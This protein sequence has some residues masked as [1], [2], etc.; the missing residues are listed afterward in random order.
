M[1]AQVD[2][3]QQV[4]ETNEN[5]NT[6]YKDLTIQASVP[7]LVVSNITTSPW[8]PSAGQDTTLTVKVKNQGTAAAGA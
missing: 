2:T 7:D 6:R 5:N 3:N 1:W 4:N 8:S